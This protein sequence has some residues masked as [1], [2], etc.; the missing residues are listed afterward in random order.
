MRE[1]PG[2]FRQRMVSCSTQSAW[3]PAG[4]IR[5]RSAAATVAKPGEV[6]NALAAS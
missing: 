4:F 6:K 3:I 5:S 1:Q 2:R